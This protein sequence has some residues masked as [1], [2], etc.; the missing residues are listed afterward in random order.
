MNTTEWLSSLV[1]FEENILFSTP[2]P[3]GI[4]PF[5]HLK[6][7]IPFLLSAPHSTIHLRNGRSKR[8][9]GFTGA[10][11]Q[12]L[13]QITGAHAI[14]A[15][16]RLPSDPNW[17]Q[18]SPYKSMLARVVEQHNIQFVLDLHGMS[19]WYKIGLALGTMN[20]RS[21][22]DET[23]VFEH[24]FIQNGFKPLNEK[25]AK[26]LPMLDWQTYVIN[27]SRFTGGLSSH[28]VTR[29]VSENLKISAAQLEICSTIRVVF[30]EHPNDAIKKFRGNHKATTQL[31][32][33]IDSIIQKIV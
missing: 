26:M 12:L 6:G 18:Y 9:D 33:T 10:F 3:A 21:C 32:Q 11:V 19:N 13:H 8:A 14:F 22:P 25:D 20:G 30:E 28:T 16:H 23:A 1:L 15:S 2:P 31:I 29:F 4:S 7:D 17:D 27:H 5:V 24:A